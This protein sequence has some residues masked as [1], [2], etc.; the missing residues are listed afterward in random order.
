L[1]YQY[2][3]GKNRASRINGL[4]DDLWAVRRA[5]QPHERHIAPDTLHLSEI[6]S[7]AHDFVRLGFGVAVTGSRIPRPSP[8]SRF[9]VARGYP[10]DGDPA[11]YWKISVLGSSLYA[12]TGVT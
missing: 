11:S 4:R 3:F 7:A 8:D 12:G 6:P 10:P 1:A 9:A 5:V 2:K